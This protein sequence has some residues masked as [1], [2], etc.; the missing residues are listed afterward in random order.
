MTEN[1]NGPLSEEELRERAVKRLRKKQDFFRHLVVFVL[2]NTFLVVIWAISGVGFFWPVFPLLGW[3]IG[4]TMHAWDTF[5]STG[6][7][8]A[9]IRREM[10]RMRGPR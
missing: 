10:D 2:V 3:G 1:E 8:E 7:G 9:R 6:F 4:L 5:A